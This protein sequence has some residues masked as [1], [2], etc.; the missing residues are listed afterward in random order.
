MVPAG[1]AKDGIYFKPSDP[2]CTLTW[3]PLSVEDGEDQALAAGE[4]FAIF[5]RAI[6]EATIGARAWRRPRR[7]PAGRFS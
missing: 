2:N 7:R 4:M 5:K 1:R 6:D 3:N